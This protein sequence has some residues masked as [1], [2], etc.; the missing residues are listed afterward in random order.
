MCWH[1]SEDWKI[2]GDCLQAHSLPCHDN[3]HS[4]S[5]VLGG[6]DWAWY[7]HGNP[8]TL[9]YYYRRQRASALKCVSLIHCCHATSV[10]RSFMAPCPDRPP[11]RE[12]CFRTPFG[13]SYSFT[14]ASWPSSLHVLGHSKPRQTSTGGL[15]LVMEAAKCFSWRWEPGMQLQCLWVRGQQAQL[16]QDYSRNEKMEKPGLNFLYS[17]FSCLYLLSFCFSFILHW[18]G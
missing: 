14:S 6:I 11:R 18:I 15:P 17:S 5:F 12:S 7:E 3:H 4:F 8:S 2:V 9:S 1:L 10:P 16:G 13:D